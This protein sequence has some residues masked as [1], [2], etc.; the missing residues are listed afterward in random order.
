MTVGSSM[1]KY[2]ERRDLIK[3]RS[4]K[5]KTINAKRQRRFLKQQHENLKKTKEK[6]E[7]L[8]YKTNCGT[9]YHYYCF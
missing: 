9:N 7:G 8:Q 3:K 4:E 5:S 2:N 1:I 6:A